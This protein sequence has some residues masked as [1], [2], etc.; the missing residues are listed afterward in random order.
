MER[1]VEPKAMDVLVR[2]AARPGE[3]VSADELIASVWHGRP[4]GDNPVHRCISILRRALGDDA[5][6]PRY[7]GTIPKRGYR[8]VAAVENPPRSASSRDAPAAPIRLCI[9]IWPF[10]SATAGAPALRPLDVERIVGIVRSIAQAVADAAGPATPV[11]SR[12]IERAVRPVTGAG[13]SAAAARRR[14]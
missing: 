5:Q 1:V 11:S 3:V 14:A 2:L 7:I 13:P 6:R 4:M 10:V 8:L 12:L 9:D